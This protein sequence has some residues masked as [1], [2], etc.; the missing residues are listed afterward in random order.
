M[1][2]GRRLFHVIQISEF[3]HILTDHFRT[4]ETTGYTMQCPTLENVQ[5]RSTNDAL[6]V[7]HGVALKI[8]PL[9][10]C[11][12][13]IE[14]RRGITAGN[15]YVWEERGINTET[16]GQGSLAAVRCRTA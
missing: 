13:D 15:V 2:N 11:Q 7:F 12:L 3:L 6:A 16:V 9:I 5:I 14:E 10:T 8:L 4:P 1:V